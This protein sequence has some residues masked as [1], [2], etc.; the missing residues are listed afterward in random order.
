MQIESI[1]FDEGIVKISETKYSK[2]WVRLSKVN[3]KFSNGWNRFLTHILHNHIRISEWSW[4]IKIDEN[5]TEK[6][7]EV[8][9]ADIK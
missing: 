1:D 4:K 6:V 2:Q 3:V 5:R 7:L 9:C 8:A